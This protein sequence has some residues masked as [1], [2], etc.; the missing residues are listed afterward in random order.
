MEREILY[1]PDY[2]INSGGVINVYEELR[3]YNRDNAME[4]AAAIYDSVAKIIEIA[5]RDNISTSRAAD[6][7]AEERIQAGKQK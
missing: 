2:V 4:K 7:M 5:K 3:G 6:Q 1:V